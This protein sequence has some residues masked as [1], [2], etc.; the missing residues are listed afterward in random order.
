MLRKAS[1]FLLA[2]MVSVGSA[3]AGVKPGDGILFLNVGYANGKSTVSGNNLDGGVFGFD[4]EKMDW[5]N[6]VSGGI[7]AGYSK[8]HESVSSDTTDYTIT[9]MPIFLG[10]KYWFGKDKIQGY[11]GAAF[12]MYFAKLEASASTVVAG[13]PVGGSYTSETGLG[14]GLGIPVGVAFSVG[15]T[16]MLSANYMLNWLWDNKF[17]D[18]DIINSAS[19]GVIFRFGD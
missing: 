15:K 18:N 4:Y 2:I 17:L 11:V 1:L 9:T 13:K 16:V 5:G 12:G 8:I 19:A 3:H 10:G 6:P 14:V 7:M